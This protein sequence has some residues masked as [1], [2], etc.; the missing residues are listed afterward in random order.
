MASTV[1]SNASNEPRSDVSSGDGTCNSRELHATPLRSTRRGVFAR[2]LPRL[3][4]APRRSHRGGCYVRPDRSL[5]S[6]A[7]FALVAAVV[8]FAVGSQAAEPTPAATDLRWDNT[9]IEL[10]PGAAAFRAM[11]Q[12]ARFRFVNDTKSA[13]EIAAVETDCN[14]LSAE[15]SIRGVV[16]GEKGEVAARMQTAGR[17]GRMEAHVTVRTRAVRPDGQ[18]PADER[19]TTLTLAVQLPDPVTVRP[20]TLAWDAIEPREWKTVTVA[21]ASDYVR[22]LKVS[23]AEEHS[24]FEVKFGALAEGEL[25]LSVRPKEGGGPVEGQIWLSCELESAANGRTFTPADRWAVPVALEAAAPRTTAEPK[26]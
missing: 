24:S 16:P 18:S 7:A 25:E 11:E 21:S 1:Y 8:L 12:Q 23:L 10:T 5:L 3:Q 9:T 19:Q 6:G 2:G 22:I 26:S 14:C 17:H 15:P 4:V 13:I 20:P